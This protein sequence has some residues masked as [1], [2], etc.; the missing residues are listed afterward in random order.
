MEDN[1]YKLLTPLLVELFNQNTISI[2]ALMMA[3][4]VM[5][6]IFTPFLGPKSVPAPVKIGLAL[7][8]GFIVWPTVSLQYT[9]HDFLGLAFFLLLIK[10]AFIGFVIGFIASKIFMLVQTAGEFVDMVRSVNQIQ[11]MV[12]EIGSRS[13]AFGTFNFQLLLALAVTLNLHFVFLDIL[14]NSFILIPVNKMPVFS[15]GTWPLIDEILRLGAN[16]FNVAAALAFPVGLVCVTL[17]F[18]FG[19]LNKAAP[20]VN[21]YFMSL[22]AKTLGGI[23]I[24]YFALNMAV[25]EWIERFIEYMGSLQNLLAALM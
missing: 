18:T 25:E 5:V 9:E 11:A 10:E 24:I 2:F 21:A 17:D 14:A 7:F 8:L 16:I 12:P 20:Q 19:L 23:V 3:R 4:L 6:V 22:P 1:L 13:S 15:N